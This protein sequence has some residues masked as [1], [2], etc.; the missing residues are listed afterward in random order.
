ML[1][2]AERQRAFKQRMLE[3]GYRRKQVWVLGEDVKKNVKMS[4]EAFL[5]KLD[6]LTAGFSD[7]KLS[8]IYRDIIALVKSKKEEY[9]AKNR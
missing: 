8:K 6:E 4:K 9:E 7:T 3:K 5:R 2:N 1:S